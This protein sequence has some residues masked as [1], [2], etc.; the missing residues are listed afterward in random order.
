MMHRAFSFFPLTAH[1]K[2]VPSHLYHICDLYHI[3]NLK[4][5][6]ELKLDKRDFF[7]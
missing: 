4:K 5:T 1:E 2:I 3:L 7:F 6:E